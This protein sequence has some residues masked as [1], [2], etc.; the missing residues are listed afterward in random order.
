MTPPFFCWFRL[1][2]LI[3]GLLVT[4]IFV[5]CNPSSCRSN[6][7]CRATN[8]SFFFC[9]FL[10]AW[11][12]NPTYS[13]QVLF[14]SYTSFVLVKPPLSWSFLLVHSC[15]NSTIVHSHPSFLEC[16]VGSIVQRLTSETVGPE[17]FVRQLGVAQLNIA[18]C[19]WARTGRCSQLP[20]CFMFVVKI[21][22]M[23]SMPIESHPPDISKSCGGWKKSCTSW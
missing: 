20:T 8:T 21:L 22:P 11:P 18:E 15:M 14:A 4:L 7:V 9:N 12:C 3:L 5:H 10:C 23:G 17:S 16:F 13:P 19:Y 6:P 1:G 2:Y